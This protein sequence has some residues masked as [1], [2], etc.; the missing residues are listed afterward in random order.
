[1]YIVIF[2]R[3]NSTYYYR[4]RGHLYP[5]SHD[6]G[7]TNQYGH[8]LILIISVTS[9]VYKKRHPIRYV[10]RRIIRKLIKWLDSILNKLD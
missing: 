10:K 5:Y 9:L 4:I 7:W 1:M 2:K 3:P 6:I 8:E